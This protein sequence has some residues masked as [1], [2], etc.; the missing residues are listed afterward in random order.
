MLTV[1]ICY[2][3]SFPILPIK[4]VHLELTSQ[5]GFIF[6]FLPLKRLSLFDSYP[7]RIVR[8]QTVRFES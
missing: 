6:H 5:S 8:I 2:M 4:M 1:V 3:E 7:E